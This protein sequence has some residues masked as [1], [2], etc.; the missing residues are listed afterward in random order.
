LIK[1]HRRDHGSVRNSR[2]IREMRDLLVGF[3]ALDGGVE[4]ETL[5]R[6][7]LRDSLPDSSGTVTSRE[8]EGSVGSPL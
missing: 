4:L 2:S 6:K 1:R 8:A 7:G 3:D 5:L